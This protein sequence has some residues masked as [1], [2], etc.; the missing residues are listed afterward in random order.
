MLDLAT[1]RDGQSTP[2][3][4]SEP[5]Q[6]WGFLA[7]CR[8]TSHERFFRDA[9]KDEE[10]ERAAFLLARAMCGQC[11]VRRECLSYAMKVEAADE[12]RM[13]KED[14]PNVEAFPTAHRFRTGMFGG[15][16]PRER[17]RAADEGW[18]LTEALLYS[19][20]QLFG[21]VAEEAVS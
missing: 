19:E 5:S 9:R 12:A 18:T 15:L 20:G 11:V 10:D 17:V 16:T 7:R 14:G 8:N 2:V 3:S 13:R 6:A 4:L 1:R 21:V